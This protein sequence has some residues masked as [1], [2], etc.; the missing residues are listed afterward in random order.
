MDLDP[1]QESEGVASVTE[2][3]REGTM[4]PAEFSSLLVNQETVAPLAPWMQEEW[5]RLDDYIQKQREQLTRQ[6]EELFAQQ[7]A[8]DQSF[9]EQRREMARQFELLGSQTEA[10]HEREQKLTEREEALTCQAEGLGRREEELERRYQSLDQA[11]TQREEDVARRWE[12]VRSAQAQ[13]TIL[14][15]A[16]DACRRSWKG[17]ELNGSPA[18]PV[19]EEER[20]APGKD[21]LSVA[22]SPDGSTSVAASPE[23]SESCPPARSG[24]AESFEQDLPAKAPEASVAPTSASSESAQEVLA[25]QPEMSLE[26][27][28]KPV[29]NM[30]PMS[31]SESEPSLLAEAARDEEST[32]QTVRSPAPQEQPAQAIRRGNPVR[33]ALSRAGEASEPIPAWIVARSHEELHL[34]A[35]E[36]VE[37]GRNLEVRR[38]A[39]YT[40]VARVR[41][42]TCRRENSW[43]ALSCRFSQPLSW[44]ELQQFS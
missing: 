13:L 31:A 11:V 16:L 12:E 41:V 18:P 27:A 24:E 33:V 2:A 43:W 38:A 17:Q 26:S 22:G 15:Q 6:R 9:T 35:H 3:R 36:P 23:N 44:Q 28:L 20:G 32:V 39:P 42:Q 37:V 29:D 8:L 14:E 1:A 7:T 25:H 19:P 5:Q 34:M 21:A 4:E 40:S 30:D 10:L